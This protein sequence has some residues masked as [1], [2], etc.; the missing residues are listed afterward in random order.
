MISS[1]GYTNT[2]IPVNFIF[3]LNCPS[4][5]IE[6]FINIVSCR[7]FRKLIYRSIHLIHLLICFNYLSKFSIYVYI[8]KLLL[9]DEHVFY[10]SFEKDGLKIVS[11]PQLIIDLMNEG[12]VCVEAAELLIK[13]TVKNV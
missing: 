9:S 12:G 3:I 6:L 7:L 13:R 1:D 2:F 11:M 10:N 4:G 8:L 5:G